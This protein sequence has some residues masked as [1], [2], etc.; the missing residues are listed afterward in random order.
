MLRL[1][2]GGDAAVAGEPGDVARPEAGGIPPG[3]GISE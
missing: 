2:A 3:N 1:R